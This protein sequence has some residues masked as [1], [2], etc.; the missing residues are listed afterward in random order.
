MPSTVT[1][2]IANGEP[3]TCVPDHRHSPISTAPV[4]EDTTNSARKSG[5]PANTLRQF[6]RTWWL[7]SKARLG[8]AGCSL[9]Y[10]GAKQSTNASRSCAFIAASNRFITS[11]VIALLLVVGA[12]GFSVA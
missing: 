11:P 6:S 3:S 12:L 2:H 5:T 7:P 9:R 4:S 10:P 1:P 8:C